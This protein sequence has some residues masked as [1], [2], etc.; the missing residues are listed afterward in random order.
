MDLVIRFAI[1]ILQSLLFLRKYNIIHCDLKP[2]NI[3]LKQKNK[4][5][6]LWLISLKLSAECVKQKKPNC[7]S[8]FSGGFSQFCT[9]NRVLGIK[10]RARHLKLVL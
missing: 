5:G 6:S 2:E 9:P 4:T 7:A 10:S 8:Q 1:Q 3:M